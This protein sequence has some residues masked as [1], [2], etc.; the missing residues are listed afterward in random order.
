[1]KGLAIIIAASIFG[2]STSYMLNIIIMKILSDN[3]GIQ[4]SNEMSVANIIIVILISLGISLVSYLF[5]LLKV[6][7]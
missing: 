1:M 3:V 6:D 2:L 7:I 5:P 4:F